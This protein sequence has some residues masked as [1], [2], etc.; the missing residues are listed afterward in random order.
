M[1]VLSSLV[2]NQQQ[3]GQ[4]NLAC[5]SLSLVASGINDESYM[6]AIAGEG[7][8]AIVFMQDAVL[9]VIVA[10]DLREFG[11][12]CRPPGSGLVTN[13]RT[14]FDINGLIRR[15]PFR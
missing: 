10:F 8:A 15:H 6:L 14:R 1:K 2:A 3:A 12:S 5:Y 13:Y 4:C 11:S 9:S 7:R